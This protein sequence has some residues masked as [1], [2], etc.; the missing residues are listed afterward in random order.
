MLRRGV[1][2]LLSLAA[3]SCTNPLPFGPGRVDVTLEDAS[4]QVL[5]N[6][7]IFPEDVFAESRHVPRQVIQFRISS[8]TDLLKYFKDWDRQLQ[9]RCS[10]EGSA[11]GRAYH[12]IGYGGLHKCAEDG[13][14]EC[15]PTPGRYRY[16][17]YSFIDLEANDDEYANGKP[18]TT[19]GL[20]TDRFESLKCH[21]IGVQKAPVLF[22]RSNDFFVSAW[23]FQ[24]LLR[25]TVMPGKQPAQSR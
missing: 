23:E 13:G 9:V 6:E 10:V 2:C 3:V 14:R 22:P 4:I 11:N 24:N 17:V 8:R 12:S 1:L 5:E 25:E 19:L 7:A 16:T 21:L 20:K 18:A 15:K